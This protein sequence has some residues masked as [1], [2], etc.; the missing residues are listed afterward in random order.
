MGSPSTPR[1]SETTPSRVST[2]TPRLA[3]DLP[4]LASLAR[5]RATAP[6]APR[7][8][9]PSTSGADSGLDAVRSLALS[10]DGTSLYAISQDDD[11]V[12]R[13]DRD[14]A[15]APSPTRAASPARPRAAPPV[16]RLHPDRQRRLVRG[17]LR[18]DTPFAVAVELGRNVPLR[19]PP[20]RTTPSPAST[21]TR[22]PAPSPTRAHHRRDRE[23]P[24]GVGPPAPRSAPRPRSASTPPSTTSFSLSERGGR[25]STRRLRNERRCRPLR[26]ATRRL[27]PLPTRAASPARPKPGPPARPRADQIGS[28]TSARQDS[29]LDKLRSVGVTTDGNSLYASSPADDPSPL[30]PRPGDRR[31]YLPGLSH[32]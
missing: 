32:R 25:P 20:C 24:R 8:E 18:L 27:A 2:A 3:P 30:R 22:R 4:G 29:G 28:A 21:A 13:F 10:T 15:T 5:A 9:A 14:R 16:G 6:P 11:A 1:P 26:T 17:Q 19:R 31:P 12:A 23:R 7:S